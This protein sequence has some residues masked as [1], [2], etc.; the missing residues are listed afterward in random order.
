MGLFRATVPPSPLKEKAAE[1]EDVSRP[2]R[3][4][5]FYPGPRNRRLDTLA[6]QDVE[7]L[8]PSS[9]HFSSRPQSISGRSIQSNTSSAILDEVKHEV[10]V[11]YLYQQQCAHLWVG[12]DSS[13]M[14]GVLLRR[15]RGQYMACP[16][17]LGSSPLAVACAALNVRVS[18]V[19]QSTA[20]LYSHSSTH[21][22]CYVVCHDG[23]LSCNQ[24][25]PP[26]DPR[27]R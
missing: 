19:S 6:P 7:L 16:P 27:C 1:T 10:M 9:S 2:S 12:D 17:E 4:Q 26:M 20:I 22:A 5:Q 18:L 23:Q 3:P 8:P 13:G 14:E 21:A 25:V 11:N 15:A 24:D